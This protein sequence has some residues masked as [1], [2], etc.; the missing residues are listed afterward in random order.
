[1]IF[2]VGYSYVKDQLSMI[3]Y[4]LTNKIKVKSIVVT[5]NIR[6]INMTSPKI[7]TDI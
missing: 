2:P 6:P 4:S 1:M 3:Y 7:D 5:I